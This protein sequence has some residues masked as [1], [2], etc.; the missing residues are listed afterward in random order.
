MRLGAMAG[1]MAGMALLV[2]SVGCDR[3]R[4]SESHG[5]VA[6]TWSPPKVNSVAGVPTSSLTQALSTRLR[7]ERPEG[8]SAGLWKHVQRLYKDYGGGVLWME[9]NGPNPTRAGALLAALADAHTDALD[10]EAYPLAQLDSALRAVR[11]ANPP[12]PEQLANADVLLSS[13]YLALAEDLMSGQTDPQS[14]TTDWHIAT[15][16]EKLDSAVVY[17]LKADRLDAGIARMRPQGEDYAN[18]QK[19][20]VAMRETVAQGGWDPVPEGDALVPGQRAGAARL[21]ALRA[22]L[23]AE[24]LLAEGGSGAVYTRQLA[25]AVAEYQARH[26]I[27]VDSILGEET[28]KSMNVPADYRLGQIA[29]NLERLRWLPNALGER[30]VYV[31][32]PAFR[33]EA[34][35][36]TGKALEMKVIVGQ[37]YEGKS[38]PVFS[39]KMEMVVFRPYWLVT[40]TIQRK[41]IAPKVAEDP[42]YLSRNNM[43]YYRD[44]GET[45][46]R[47]RPGGK[48]SLGLVKFLFPND[49]NIYLHDTPNDELFEKDVR[50]FSH[51]CI[52][53]EKPAELAQWVLGWDAEKVQNA[54][55][56]GSDNRTVQLPSKIPVYI[57]YMTA[58][59][60]DGQLNF[61]NDLYSRDESLVRAVM[62]GAAPREEVMRRLASLQE[63]V[64]E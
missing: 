42:S 5:E 48:N 53:V 35:D 9:A 22:R 6:Y 61:G 33:L 7:G 39:D 36:S 58:F 20:L 57:T 17:S 49:F 50:A 18:L 26:A 41:E 45:R 2:V 62:P 60:R 16:H 15:D 43:E 55:E 13:A 47:Q 10:L 63:L 25:G 4:E 51:G 31:N 64:G 44:G 52:R 8:V 30:Y 21:A 3:K 56:N 11:A 40:P 32:V 19:A 34:W 14:V 29:A 46:I 23:Q 37:E 27:G 59:T 28:V 12:T 1:W 38:T 54:M 24:G